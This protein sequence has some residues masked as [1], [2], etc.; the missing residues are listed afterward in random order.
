MAPTMYRRSR[1][2]ELADAMHSSHELIRLKLAACF[3]ASGFAAH[4]TGHS[5]LDCP[6]AIHT[7][8]ASMS[9]SRIVLLVPVP[10]AQKDHQLPGPP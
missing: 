10:P 6:A 7:S 9:V 8:P 2:P 1:R 3:S 5:I 4:A